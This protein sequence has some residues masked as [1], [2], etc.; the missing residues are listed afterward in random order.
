MCGICGIY[1]YQN[2]EPVN[3]RLIHSMNNTMVHRGPDD[4]GYYLKDS[5]MLGMRRLSI[6]DVEGGHQPIHNEDKSIWVVFNGEIYNFKELR[7]DLKNKGHRFYTQSDTEVIVHSY[8]E[9]GDD[10][11]LRFNGIFGLAIWDDKRKRLL[12]A[13][14]PHGVKPLY[15]FNDGK[16]LLWSSE[17]KA[18]LSDSRVPRAV[19]RQSLDLFLTFRFVPSPFTLFQG[20]RKI[21]PG[22]KL[23]VENNNLY[24]TRYIV[25]EAVT[26]YQFKEDDYINVLQ[27]KLEASVKRQMVSDVPIGVLLSGGID[28]AVV[29]AIMSSIASK[30]IETFSVGFKNEMDVNELDEARYTAEYFGANHHEVLLDSLDYSEWLQKAIWY[31]EEPIATTSSL[32]M[33][34]V[35]KLAKDYVKVV[36]TGQGADEPFCGYYRYFGERYGYMYRKIPKIIRN[37]FLKPIVE[38]LSRQ[39]RIKRAVRS[40][41]TDE[42]ERR[43]VQIYSVFNKEMR[44]SLWRFEHKQNIDESACEEIVHYWRNGL[45]DMDPLIQMSMIDTRLSLADDLLMYGD[46]MSMSNSI[47]A[48]VPFL[49]HEYMSLVESLPASLRIR[50]FTRKYIHKKATSKWLPNQIIKR[51]KRGF[52]TPVDRWFRTELSGFVQSTLLSDKSASQNY[53]RKESINS[54]IQ[55]HISGRQNNSRQLFCLVNF[56]LWH[57]TFIER[58]FDYYG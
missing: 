39:E 2:N 27:E 45:E 42:I 25:P 32:P 29:L 44:D 17:I 47:E 8:E 48:R 10:C 53:F 15:V 52:E 24:D 40:M 54:L 20:I 18:I 46:K 14:D 31:L 34:F 5:L 7:N 30:P 37:Q 12:L 49:D 4:E 16:R 13:R 22:H 28:S 23:V 55:D 1:N 38:S 43:F 3:K 57:K 9:W 6:I 19:D 36:L 51:K 41:G 33:Y 26:N 50:G 21:R 56:E 35:T 11:L 58:S